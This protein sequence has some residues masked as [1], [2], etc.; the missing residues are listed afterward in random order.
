[1]LDERW[2]INHGAL[3]G[4]VGVETVIP[5]STVLAVL[6]CSSPRFVPIPLSSLQFL[7]IPLY[8]EFY[9]PLFFLEALL[10]ICRGYALPVGATS[11]VEATSSV[12]APLH[13]S[14]PHLS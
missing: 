2:T 1:M 13:L 10:V 3:A 7:T 14:R 9:F 5:C 6:P 4:I 12:E 11:F 8:L